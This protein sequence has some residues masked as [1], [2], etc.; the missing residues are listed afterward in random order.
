VY[1]SGDLTLWCFLVHFGHWSGEWCLVGRGDGGWWSSGPVV[2]LTRRGVLPPQ[3]ALRR[4][5]RGDPGLD[6]EQGGGRQRLA[7][8]RLALGYIFTILGLLMIVLFFVWAFASAAT[9]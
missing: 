3:G 9:A 5:W 2:S 6:Q 8:G 7:T 1:V 4:R